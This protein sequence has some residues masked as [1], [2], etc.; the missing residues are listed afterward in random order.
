MSVLTVIQGE[1]REE[2]AFEGEVRLAALLSDYGYYVA[3]PCSRGVCKKCTVTLN[4]KS[5]LACKTVLSENCTVILPPPEKMSVLTAEGETGRLTDNICLCLDI[6]STTLALALVSLDEGSVIATKSAPNPQRAFGADVMSRI[7]Y[8]TKNG[9][10]QLQRAVTSAVSALCEALLSGY[11][12]SAVPDMYV[13]GNTTMLHLFL[14]EDPSPM[15]VFPYTPAFLDRRTVEG[16]SIG[17]MQAERVTALE[18]I[19]AFVGA[20]IVS[21]LRATGLPDKKYNMLIDL[22]TNAEIALFSRDRILVSAAAAGP[23]FEGANISCGMSAVSGAVHAVSDDGHVSV[24]GDGEPSGLCATGL[25]DAVAYGKK[26]GAID[27]SGYMEGDLEICDGVTLLQKDVREFQLAKSAI[28]AALECLIKRAG[29]T[30][31]DIGTLY[32]SGGFSAGLDI[33]NAVYLGLVSDE[34]EEKAVCISNSSLAGTVKYAL[35][36]DFYLPLEN[37][38]YIDLSADAGFSMLFME[39]MEL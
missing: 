22:G 25:I 28:R 20:D 31:E 27:P 5:V 11:L 34:L 2:I 29:I 4:G 10:S 13:S 1:K 38:E 14:G 9:V 21:G 24:I 35:S 17:I 32:I 23:C 26:T 7:D 19:S 37:S 12:L 15:G 30:A 3:Q 8:C 39:Y 6:G 36:P 33:K 18:G 16:K